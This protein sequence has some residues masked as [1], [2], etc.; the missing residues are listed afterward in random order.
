MPAPKGYARA[1][2]MPIKRYLRR[3]HSITNS[4]RPG[5]GVTVTGDTP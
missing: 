1:K 5:E 3:A 2:S 4:L